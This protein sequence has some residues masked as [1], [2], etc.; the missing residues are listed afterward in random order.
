MG[1]QLHTANQAYEASHALLQRCQ[2]QV[3]FRCAL[4]YSYYTG[5]AAGMFVKVYYRCLEA[6][7][8]H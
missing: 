3:W 4:G 6:F 2:V 5:A 1:G 7:N 8:R